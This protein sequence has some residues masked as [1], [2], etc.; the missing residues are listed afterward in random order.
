MRPWTTTSVLV[1]ICVG[2]LPACSTSEPIRAVESATVTFE[3]GAGRAQECVD[4]LNDLL[5]ASR[6]AAHRRLSC[7]LYPPERLPV[8]GARGTWFETRGDDI[9]VMRM[10]CADEAEVDA[11]R[12]LLQRVLADS[13]DEP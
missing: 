4:L 13:A 10:E 3:V 8:R 9:V 7:A 6:E 11:V 5:E 1:S 2:F 12:N